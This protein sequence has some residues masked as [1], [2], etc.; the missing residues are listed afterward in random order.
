[1][2]QEGSREFVTPG[3]EAVRTLGEQTWISKVEVDALQGDVDVDGDVEPAGRAE[4]P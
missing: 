3:P 2:I 1:M 4:L